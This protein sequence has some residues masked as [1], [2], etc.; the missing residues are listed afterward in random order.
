MEIHSMVWTPWNHKIFHSS[1][2][3]HIHSQV[4]PSQT[5]DWKSSEF[6]YPQLWNFS[7]NF[8]G[9]FEVLNLILLLLSSCRF[10]IWQI[11]WEGDLLCVCC[12][13]IHFSKTLCLLS[14]IKF[15]SA[16]LAH[17]H[18]LPAPLSENI[19]WDKLAAYLGYF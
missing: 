5:L 16:S 12:R 7:G 6:L 13:P 10:K 11:S 19:P 17:T 18:Q 2:P 14:T 1:F 15:H 8:F 3:A 9:D 4:W